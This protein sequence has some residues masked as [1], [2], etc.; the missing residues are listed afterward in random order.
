[1]EAP[2]PTHIVTFVYFDYQRAD[3]HPARTLI[4][5]L[6]RQVIRQLWPDIL[7]ACKHWLQKA[8]QSHKLEPAELEENFLSVLSH[9]EKCYIVVD[10][11]DESGSPSERAELLTLLEK[12]AAIKSVRLFIT[13]RLGIADIQLALQGAEE[14][15][16]EADRDDLKI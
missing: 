14:V 6:L 8:T 1:M 7:I 3:P 15:R 16:V 13:S 10:A 2:A 11:L 5:S 12:L 4:V 9:V